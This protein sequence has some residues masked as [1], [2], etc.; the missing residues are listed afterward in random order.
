MRLIVD[1]FEGAIAVV[2]LEDGS[3]SEI[4]EVCL[5]SDAK[6]GSI[7]EIVVKEDDTEKKREEMKNKM[8]S[9]FHK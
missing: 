3:V 4:P 6:E 2:E 5:P 9:L 7:I 1:R 8:N